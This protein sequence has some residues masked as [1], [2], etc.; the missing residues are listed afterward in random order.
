MNF[1]HTSKIFQFLTLGH[2]HV[3]VHEL[4]HAISYYVITGSKPTIHISIK[5]CT[6]ETS[7]PDGTPN[8]PTAATWIAL[9]GSLADIIFSSV[10][11]VGI[12]AIT[13]YI[14]MPYGLSLG[15]RIFITTTSGMW[16]LGELFYSGLGA[17]RGNGD[18]GPIADRGHMHLFFAMA[19]LV[20]VCALCVLGVAMLI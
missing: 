16:I 17:Y 13:H 15:L 18:F 12:F 20:T 8:S 7:Y 4:G 14:Q 2:L 10:L 9:S 6:G 3:L 19:I 11:I 5:N 1:F